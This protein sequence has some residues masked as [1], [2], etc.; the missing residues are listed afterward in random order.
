MKTS[1]LLL[2]SLF[3]VQAAPAQKPGESGE[4]VDLGQLDQSDLK[5][6]NNATA[7][8][9]DK[10]V[11]MTFPEDKSYPGVNIKAPEGTWDLSAYRGVVAEVVNNGPAKL[12]VSLRVENPGDWRQSPWNANVVWLAPGA[13]GAV[14]VIFGESF[15]KPG[16]ELDPARVS[17]V[18]IF[19]NTP[20]QAG[21]ILVQS[22]K[23]VEK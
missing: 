17:Q 20:K 11:K 5:A 23:G 2:L 21:E 18:K 8:I 22:I 14:E 16:Y 3:L 19:V 7:E 10:A 12:G 15:G 4:L 1:L 6:E 13:S 9:A